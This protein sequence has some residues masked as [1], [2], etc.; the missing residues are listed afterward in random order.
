MKV[1]IL[2]EVRCQGKIRGVRGKWC[3]ALAAPGYG[4]SLLS[5]FGFLGKLFVED[6]RVD[7]GGN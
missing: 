4:C 3:D 1:D 6:V 5:T 7:S 2:C